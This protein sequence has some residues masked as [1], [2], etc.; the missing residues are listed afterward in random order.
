MI[1]EIEDLTKAILLLFYSI[2]F[3]LRYLYDNIYYLRYNNCV[4][5]FFIIK[6]LK[7]TLL[8]KSKTAILQILF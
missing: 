1:Y 5:D 8:A 4:L 2:F 6:D 7:I 3:R